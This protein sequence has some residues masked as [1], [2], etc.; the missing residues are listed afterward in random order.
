MIE[1]A[2]PIHLLRTVL[3]CDFETGSLTWAARQ[4]EIFG[5]AIRVRGWN[6]RHAG[7]PAFTTILSDGYRR[8]CVL[9]QRHL[10]HRVIWALRYGVWPVDQIDHINGVRSDNRI[11]NLRV[12]SNM[13]NGRN[14]RLR[15]NNTSGVM[16]VCWDSKHCMWRSQISVCGK[17]IYLGLYSS[18]DEAA[19]ARETAKIR[20]GFHQ[21][22][23][24]AA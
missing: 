6:T 9:N 8:G 1:R 17:T 4:K 7:K 14:Q 22:H 2:I 10:A 24:A 19:S 5:D 16:G 13:E 11:S 20:F 21:N 15:K 23:G 18:L 12:V 3:A